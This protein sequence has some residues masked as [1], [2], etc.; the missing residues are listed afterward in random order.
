M[1]CYSLVSEDALPSPTTKLLLEPA[2]Q[3]FQFPYFF[4]HMYGTLYEM[5]ALDQ[6]IS[7]ISLQ[8]HQHTR[9]KEIVKEKVAAMGAFIQGL[10]NSG[11]LHGRVMEIL[12][13]EVLQL[14]QDKLSAVQA[15]W[16]LFSP[17]AQ[18]L[19]QQKTI[20][21]FQP[22]LSRL[23]IDENISA[24]H[25]KLYHRSFITL[26]MVRIG[27][28]AFL[29]HF[30][31]ILVEAAGGYR[32]FNEAENLEQQLSQED[33]TLPNGCDDVS[34]CDVSEGVY[35]DG[36]PV[37]M[38]QRDIPVSSIQE[39]NGD[40]EDEVFDENLHNMFFEGIDQLTPPIHES[41]RS[42]SID[43]QSVTS[44]KFE[45]ES[46]SSVEVSEDALSK[47][48]GQ[49][50]MH[51]VSRLIQNKVRHNSESS[52]EDQSSQKDMSPVSVSDVDKACIDVE[53]ENEPAIVHPMVRSETEEFPCS[54]LDTSAES[55]YN[56]NDVAAE[57]IKWLAHRLGPVLT[58]QYLSGNL[59]R[60][61]VL[62]YMGEEQLKPA[63]REG[64]IYIYFFNPLNT[65]LFTLILALRAL[66]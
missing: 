52:T 30:S 37:R 26:V 22:L 14:C 2:F 19:G 16:T 13:S 54:L 6:K 40:I 49:I 62:C 34:N 23:L 64:T 5:K 48:A 60:M 27:L 57:T 43:E 17:V 36:S 29:Q 24:K 10:N 25:I 63:A 45:T 1:F 50:S 59:L 46:T 4:E 58:T 18:A 15:T 8:Q 51:S 31:T 21:H 3:I 12:V 53:D 66:S 39:T 38:M 55:E 44:E 35:L 7:V 32:N 20:Q 56:I 47:S 42:P 28:H 9:L 33:V 11:E 41:S 65:Q 61:L